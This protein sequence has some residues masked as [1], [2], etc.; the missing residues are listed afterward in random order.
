MP[1]QKPQLR[2]RIFLPALFSLRM[3]RGLIEMETIMATLKVCGFCQNTGKHGANF[4][5]CVDTEELRVHKFCG[6]K[7]QAE[8]P[9]G[10]TVRLVHFA[11]LRREK[12][13]SVQSA[14]QE[15]VRA[16]WA[17]K[18]AQAQRRKEEKAA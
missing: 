1:E 11:E 17:E 3:V 14:E 2:A 16:F 9:E 5:L 18:F 8:A 6:E 15:R 4:V 10:A 7:L 13:A 12:A